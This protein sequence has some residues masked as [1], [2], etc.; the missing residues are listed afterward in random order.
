MGFPHDLGKRSSTARRQIGS[1]EEKKWLSSSIR[2]WGNL[3]D[4]VPYFDLRNV[5]IKVLGPLFDRTTK[6]A[7]F[8]AS[9]YYREYFQVAIEMILVVSASR[10]AEVLHRWTSTCHPEY[11]WKNKDT[12]RMYAWESLAS[13]WVLQFPL[14]STSMLVSRRLFYSSP[15]DGYPRPFFGT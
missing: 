15:V 2:C 13:A 11:R 10:E 5:T 9:S 1:S 12:M 6:E 3:P 14:P 7:F 4:T 8:K